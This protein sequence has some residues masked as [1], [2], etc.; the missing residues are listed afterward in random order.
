MSHF[1]CRL[2]RLDEGQDVAEY[3]VLM[4]VMIVL[5]LGAVRLAGIGANDA[6]SNLSPTVQ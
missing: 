1:L 3:A 6:F 2:L 4:A 5:V